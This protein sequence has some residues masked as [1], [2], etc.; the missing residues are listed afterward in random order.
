M[1]SNIANE[2]FLI[3]SDYIFFTRRLSV[4]SQIFA[5]SV[6]ILTCLIF[7]STMCYAI[8]RTASLQNLTNV[9]TVNLGIVDLL[10]GI[11]SLPMWI[12]TLLEIQLSKYL[13]QFTAFLTVLL[14][15]CSVSILAGISLDRYFIICHPL[16]YPTY[17]TKNR[18]VLGVICIWSLS[19]L[20]A[21]MPIFGWGEYKFRP[22]TLPICNPIWTTNSAYAGFLACFSI[23]LPFFIMLFSYIRIMLVAREQ[24]TKIAQITRQLEFP[25]SID[26]DPRNDEEQKERKSGFFGRFSRAP[27]RSGVTTYQNMT[28]NMKTLRTVFIAVGK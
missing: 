2:T 3:P 16:R 26:I 1:S 23:I 18:V 24:Q 20:Y 5:I 4:A 14:L 15:T 17:V 8:Y 13:C 11:F 10:V 28:R 27:N 9:F 22:Q 19:T 6:I 7:N 21:L 25:Q 12:V